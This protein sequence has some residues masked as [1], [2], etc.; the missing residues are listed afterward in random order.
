MQS[1]LRFSCKANEK[2]QKSVVGQY[3]NTS[4]SGT[5]HLAFSVKQQE[6]KFDRLKN[7]RDSDRLLL[8]DKKH[9]LEHLSFGAVVKSTTRVIVIQSTNVFATYLQDQLQDDME[10]E[11][12]IQAG[13]LTLKQA[14]KQKKEWEEEEWEKRISSLPRKIIIGICKFHATAMMMRSLEFLVEKLFDEFTL[15]RLTT[16]SFDFAQRL[17]RKTTVISEIFPKMMN[18]C[19]CS[20]IISFF[21]DFSVHQV[22]LSYTY[23]RYYTSRN[24]SSRKRH[25]PSDSMEDS[26]PLI[27]SYLSK[28]TTLFFSRIFGLA[29]SSFGGGLGS[30]LYPGWGTLIGSQ[31]GD[32]LLSS[33]FD[34]YQFGN[35]KDQLL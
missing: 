16:D 6:A 32:V 5:T 8:Q 21:A 30:M 35:S 29:A 1:I 24:N 31:C 4:Y 9:W 3:P 15:D 2:Q 26:L 17:A 23:Y 25:D 11:E 20:S 14:D 10:R 34:E 27:F 28:T 12:E 13:K 33:I 22:I 19:F 7:A 18:V